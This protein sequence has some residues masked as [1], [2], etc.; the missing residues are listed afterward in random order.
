MNVIV[1]AIVRHLVAAAGATQMVNDDQMQQLAGGLVT[2]A[3]IGW[4]VWEKKRR[5]DAD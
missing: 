4:S 1:L 5:A 3:M 2:L